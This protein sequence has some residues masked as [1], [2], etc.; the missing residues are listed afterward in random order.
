[1]MMMSNNKQSS[2]DIKTPHLDEAINNLKILQYKNEISE[3]GLLKLEEFQ[4]IKKTLLMSN[5]KQS[6]IE[7]LVEQIQN[8][9]HHTIR[10]PSDTIEQAKAMHK[11]EIE[12]SYD[13]MRCIGSFTNG[14]EYYNETFK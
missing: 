8:N 5:N 13:Y 2:I 12:N 1:M 6:S 10:I 4:I 9:I 11:Q 7:W 14:K 3:Y